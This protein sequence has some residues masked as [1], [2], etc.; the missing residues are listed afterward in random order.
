MENS[1]AMSSSIHQDQDLA[2]IISQETIR[3]PPAATYDLASSQE[4]GQYTPVQHA[5]EEDL[6]QSWVYQRS[7]AR[8]VRFSVTSSAQ[9]S[10]SWSMLSGLSLSNISN[11]AVQS[12]PIFEKD[13][14]NSQVYNFG[15]TVFKTTEG[16]ST[17]PTEDRATRTTKSINMEL[18]EHSDFCVN[19]GNHSDS[20]PDCTDACRIYKAALPTALSNSNQSARSIPFLRRKPVAQQKLQQPEG[21]QLFQPSPKPAKD[22][23]A[24]SIWYWPAP[25]SAIDFPSLPSSHVLQKNGRIPLSARKHVQKT[26]ISTPKLVSSSYKHGIVENTAPLQ[27]SKLAVELGLREE[28]VGQTDD[29][30]ELTQRD[31]ISMLEVS[32][33]ST[34]H[35][36]FEDVNE[37]IHNLLEEMKLPAARLSPNDS[38]RSSISSPSSDNSNDTITYDTA[39]EDEEESS[40][41]PYN[42]LYLA[43][44]VFEFNIPETKIEAGYPYLMYQV[45][46]VN[47]QSSFAAHLLTGDIDI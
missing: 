40:A 31:S 41:K 25:P 1:M 5:F 26:S 38:P 17:I 44:S 39:Q 45:G 47:F 24:S 30:P 12:L 21:E 8:D 34:S 33:E 4:S 15:R 32:H 37:E 19:Y 35:G 6:E 3:G 43:A 16:E 42:I 14:Q 29:R 2:S 18:W 23:D 28:S 36:H 46:E 20:G 11:I 27:P 13:L 9:L 10:L 7:K 22:L